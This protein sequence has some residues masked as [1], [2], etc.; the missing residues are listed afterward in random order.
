MSGGGIWRADQVQFAI[1]EEAVDGTAP[2]TIATMPGLIKGGITLPD[3]DYEWDPFFGVG[4]SG[5]A[6]Q[7]IHEGP[8]SFRGSIPQMQIGH[9]TGRLAL[10][11]SIGEHSDDVVTLAGTNPGVITSVDETTMTDSGEDFTSVGGGVKDGNFAVFSGISVGYIDTTVGGGVTEV[12]VFPTP[13]RSGTKGWNGPQPAVGDEYEI[14]KTESVGTGTSDKFL[15][16]TQRQNTMSWAVR[17]R[18]SANHGATSVGSNLTVNYLGGKVNR[19]SLSAQEGGKLTMAW[20]EVL[21]RD[22][23]HDVALPSTSVAKYSGSTT[24]PTAT[25]PTEEPLVFSQ[26]TLSLFELGNT[27]ARITSFR[28]NVDNAIT[29]KRYIA[30]N[31]VSGSASIAQVPFELIEGNRVITLEMD[32]VME[33]REYWEH[34]MRQG[35]NDA[36]SAKTGFDFAMKFE[37]AAGTE[38][39]YIQGPAHANPVIIA[40][41]SLP[42]NTSN[43][44]SATS[45][46]GCVLNSAPHSIG[47]EGEPLIAVRLSIDVPNLVMWW[48]DA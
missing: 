22:L 41:N 31:T 12:T 26:G 40:D 13:N 6:R 5:R 16:P 9:E 27:F 11:L 42:I 38:F 45:N 48:T 34:L 7:D 25:Q 17:H 10:E 44:Q 35:Q 2:G 15:V 4:R 21:F 33:T 1:A 18:N 28:L 43:A 19:W 37:N 39:F 36:L 29:E 14:R 20:D 8:Q 23:R 30:K 47:P 24:A 46:V 3:V 32:T